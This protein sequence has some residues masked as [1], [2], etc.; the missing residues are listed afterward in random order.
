VAHHGVDALVQSAA[1]A[2]PEG[3][4]LVQALLPLAA[5]LISG[6]LAGSLVLAGVSLFKRLFARR[7]GSPAA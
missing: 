4:L 7:A 3:H 6:L 5:D 1:L 2:W